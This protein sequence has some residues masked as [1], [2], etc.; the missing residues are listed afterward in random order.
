MANGMETQGPALEIEL[1]QTL[2]VHKPAHKALTIAHSSLRLTNDDCRV[3]KPNVNGRGALSLDLTLPLPIRG[4]RRRTS[5]KRATLHSKIPG[6]FYL[7]AHSSCIHHRAVHQ[8]ISMNDL[9]CRS[10]TQ[11]VIRAKRPQRL[12]GPLIRPAGVHRQARVRYQCDG[13]RKIKVT[14]VSTLEAEG[15]S[16]RIQ[17]TMT[18]KRTRRA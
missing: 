12:S 15:M 14:M 6:F 13:S 7:V 18:D 17:S 3:L 5:Q 11:G 10:T 16:T 2:R 1:E 9:F 4:H 8:S